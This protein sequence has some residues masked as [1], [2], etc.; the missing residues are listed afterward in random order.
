MLTVLNIQ[1]VKFPKVYQ[2]SGDSR[3]DTP[4]RNWSSHGLYM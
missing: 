3:A 2:L 4:A 1:L